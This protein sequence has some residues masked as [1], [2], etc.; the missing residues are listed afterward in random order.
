MITAPAV[1]IVDV[2]YPSF[3]FFGD[4]VYVLNTPRGS[5]LYSDP[6]I[7]NFSVSALA[8]ENGSVEPSS[9]VVYYSPT[10]VTLTATPEDGYVFSNWSGD[11]A[12]SLSTNNPV[13][14][15]VSSNTTITANFVASGTTDSGSDRIL[16]SLAN[17]IEIAIE[18]DI[19]TGQVSSGLY[20]YNE[21]D[22]ISLDISTGELFSLG[23]W[24]W[25]P[26][27]QRASFGGDQVF[28]IWDYRFEGFMN[29]YVYPYTATIYTD[30]DNPTV[31]TGT[32]TGVYYDGRAD[33]DDN[34]KM[35]LFQ[36]RDGDPFPDSTF[37]LSLTDLLNSLSTNLPESALSLWTNLTVGK[38]IE[39]KSYK[40]T[41][42]DDWELLDTKL[43]PLDTNQDQV[44]IKSEV[45]ILE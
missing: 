43:V 17:M 22:Y 14:L 1:N 11:I 38:V 25:D 42:L 29:S 34:G 41:N 9:P 28:Q 6:L 5:S 33:L 19:S 20:L 10:E 35:D 7:T 12:D 23:T 26:V 36:I 4:D 24:A 44:F 21:S 3:S 30:P 16:Q 8:G 32:A 45:N 15:S 18:T 27:S 40:S 2:N 37:T 13:I 31:A 39:Y